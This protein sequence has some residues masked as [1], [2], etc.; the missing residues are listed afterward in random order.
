M[1]ATKNAIL[2]Y[3]II[4]RCLRNTGRRYSFEDI[5]SIIEEELS[6]INPAWGSI[7]TRALRNDMEYMRSI[8]GYD[9]PIETYR[10][11]K[12]HFY[13]YK[14]PKFSI[15]NK[16]INAAEAEKMI[17][18][19]AVLERFQGGPQFEW[20]DEIIP[21]FKSHF[22][23]QGKSHKAMGF[24]S[25][26]DYSGHQ[27]ITTLFNAITNR[28]VLQ[29]KYTSFKGESFE[30]YFHPYYLKQYNNRWFVFGY[31]QESNIAQWNM[32]L[33]RIIELKEAKQPYKKDTTDWDDYFSDM[34]G[35]T[36][37][38]GAE[39]EKVILRFSQE[40]TPYILTKPIHESQLQPIHNEDGTSDIR[41]KV[42]VNYELKQRILSFGSSVTVV[43]PLALKEDIQH[44]IIQ[45]H[46][47]YN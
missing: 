1:P 14:D 24:E 3:R 10:D 15:E 4:D 46:Q 7:S 23:I 18:A 40:Q 2:R 20:L 21:L 5:K 35:V 22:G 12:H 25:N 37:P 11:G 32:P 29:V 44:T 36:K 19:I 28:Q 33:D 13:R 16:P 41:L 38:D 17:S 6:E 30:F 34:I 31:N 8:D 26:I 43:E 47:N 9:A 39:V 27:H 42:I 45:M